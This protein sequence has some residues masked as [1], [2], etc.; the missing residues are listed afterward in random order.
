MGKGSSFSDFTYGVGLNIN[1]SSFKQVKNDLKINLDNLSKMVK[2]Y[3]EILKINPDA[4]LS[5]LFNEMVKIKSIVDGINSS[6]NSFSGFV[7][8]GVLTRISSLE[9]SLES[10]RSMSNEVKTNLSDL[11]ASLQSALSP[12]KEAGKTKIPGTFDNLFGKTTDHSTQIQTYVEQIKTLENEIRT[13]KGLFDEI[14]TSFNGT[15]KLGQGADTNQIRAW[16]ENF[17]DL[18]DI[19]SDK[20]SLNSDELSRYSQQVVD[21]GLKLNNA[22]NSMSPDQLKKTFNVDGGYISE[23]RGYIEDV[24]A[25]FDN[26]ISTIE[27]KQKTLNEKLTSARAEQAKYEA[28][29]SKKRS[30]SKSMGVIDDYTAQVPITPKINESDWVTKINTSIANIEGSIKPVVLTPTFSHNSKSIEKEIADG[31]A[32]INHQVKVNLN[33]VDGLGESFDKKIKDIDNQ[34]LAAKKQL[35]S[36]TSFKIKFEYEDGENFK[37]SAGKI[38]DQFKNIKAS[39]YIKNG[40]KFL[41]DVVDLRTQAIQELTN[42][43]A[44][45][46]V[47]N[48]NTELSNLST[49]REDIEKKIGNIGVNLNIQNLPQLMAQ[50]TLAKDTIESAYSNGLVGMPAGT[51][52]EVTGV[53]NATSNIEQLSEAAKAAKE[54]LEKCK[55]ALQ[56]LTT[57]GFDA[58]EFLQLGDLSKNG[59]Q[60]KGSVEKLEKLLKRR[61]ELKKRLYDDKTSWREKYPE[62]NG[63]KSVAKKMFLE[64]D[65]EL[66]KMDSELNQILQKQIAYTQ[67]RYEQSEKILQQE[68][69][70]AS[71]KDS[72]SN[73]V[74]NV[75]DSEKIKK[76][77]N[78]LLELNNL[79]KELQTNGFK[80]SE[81]LKIGDIGADGNKIEESTKKLKSLLAEYNKLKKRTTLVKDEGSDQ[82]FKRY[83]KAKGDMSKVQKMIAKDEQKMQK[84]ESELNQ[85]S[86]KQIAF[87]SSRASSLQKTLAT[88]KQITS[89]NVKQDKSSQ[90]GSDNVGVNQKL[91]MSAEEAKAKIKSLNSVLSDQKKILK[92]LDTNGINSSSLVRLGEWDKET[93]SFKKNRQEMQALVNRYKELQAARKQAGETKVVG[94]EA[95]LRGKLTSILIQQKQHASEIIAQNQSELKAAKEIAKAYRDINNSKKT[96]VDSKTSSKA[97][98]DID[99]LLIKLNKAKEALELLKTKKLDALTETGLGDKKNRLGASGSSQSFDQLIAEY[100]ALIQKRN[101]LEKSGMNISHPEYVAYAKQFQ[102]VEQQLNVIYNDQLK[103]TESRVKY[104]DTQIAKAKELLQIETKQ[105]AETKNQ[106]TISTVSKTATSGAQSGSAVVKL[107]GAT[108]GSLA[109]DGTLQSIDGKVGNILS[110]L[111]G[112]L[113][114]SSSAVSI[115]ASNVVVSGS[116]VAG[117]STTTGNNAAGKS[118]NVNNNMVNAAQGQKELNAEIKNTAALTDEVLAKSTVVYNEMSKEIARTTDVYKTMDGVMERTE[119][120][121]LFSHG[122]DAP[123]T[124]E[125]V[126]TVYKTNSEAYQNLYNDYIKSLSIQKQIEQQI[127]SSGGSTEKLKEELKVRQEITSGL[128]LQLSKYTQLYT[129]QAKQEAMLQ[130]TKKAQQEMNKMQGADRDKFVNKQN[131]DIQKIV[132]AAQSKYD[133]MQFSMQQSSVPMADAAIRKFKEYGALLDELKIKQQQIVDNP[134]LLKDEGYANNFATLLKQMG[135]VES[136]F[137]GLQKSSK[138]FLSK[139][140][141]L[142][143]IKPLDQTFDPSNIEQMRNAMQG[144]ANQVGLGSAKLIDFSNITKTAFFEVKDGSGHVQQLAVSYDAA[145]NSLGRYVVKTKESA[146]ETQVFINSLKKSF[147]N[148]ARYIASF[149]SI[150]RLW[151]IIKQGFTYV[152]DIDSALTDLK[153]VTD[154]TDLSYSKFLDNM[155]ETGKRVGATVTDLT[156]MA[157][158][159]ARLGYSMQEAG[160]L[161]ESTAILMNVS[162]FSDATQASEALISTMQ[163]FQYTADQSQH[164]VDI[165]NE[166]GNNYAISSDGIATALQHSA[167]ALMEAGNS[168]EQ[169]VAIIAAANK[170]VQDPNSVGTAMRTIALR[171]RGTS[172]QVLEEMGEETDGVI[173]SVSKLQSKIKALSGV[174]ILTATGDYKDTYTILKEIGSVWEDMSDIDQAALLELMAGKNRANTLSAILSNMEDLEDA[175]NDALKAEGSALRENETYLNSIQGRIDIFN[176]SVQTMWMHFVDTDA[177]KNF[178]NLGTSIIQV[179]DKMGVLN[180]AFAGLLSYMNMSSKFNL[181]FAKMFGIHDK[182][183]GWLYKANPQNANAIANNQFYASLQNYKSV[184]FTMGS[185]GEMAQQI[186]MLNQKWG[187]GQT[188]LVQYVNGLGDAD[189]AL[190]AYAA[191]VKDGQYSMAGYQEFIMQ[192]NAALKASSAAARGAAIA[193]QFL[194]TAM[195]IGITMLASFAINSLIK[196]FDDMNTSAEEIEEAFSSAISKTQEVEKSFRSLKESASD[197]I[198]RFA[199]LAKGVDK[200]GNNVSLTDGEYEEFISMNNRLAELFPEINMG[201]D[202]NGN[203]MLSLSYTADNLTESLNKLVEAERKIANTEIAKTIP[204]I[205]AGINQ[206]TK[207]YKEEHDILEK[208]IATFEEAKAKLDEI[209]SADNIATLK[210]TYGDSWKKYLEKTIAN[211]GIAN[212]AEAAWGDYSNDQDAEAWEAMMS[213]YRDANYQVDW[214]VVLNSK[215]FTSRI[216]GFEKQIYDTDNRISKEWASINPIITAWLGTDAEYLELDGEMQKIVSSMVNNIDFSKLGLSNEAGIKQYVREHILYP[217]ADASP[218]VQKKFSELMSID[219]KDISAKDYIKKIKNLVRELSD[220]TGIDYNELLQST[221]YDQTINRY[222]QVVN[223]IHDILSDSITRDYQAYDVFTKER[224]GAYVDYHKQLNELKDKIYDLSPD[225]LTKAFDIVKTYGITTWDDLEK[226][227]QNKTFDIVLEYD[228]EKEGLDNL[229]SAIEESISATGLSAESIENLEKRYKDLD[230]YDPAKLFER[231]AHGIHL[232]SQALNELEAEYEKQN[233]TDLD[234]KITGL[235]DTYNDLTDQI[236]ECSDAAKRSELYDQRENV[237]QQINDAATL[238]AQY[239]ALTSAYNKWQNAQSGGN[240]R[241]MY[242]SIHSGKQEIDE[243]ISRGWVDDGTKAYLELLS[244][245]DLSTS[246]VEKVLDVYKELNNE[247]AAGYN[248]YDFFTVD[249]NGE[250]TT[251]G[252]YNFF[253]TVMAKQKELGEEWVKIDENGNYV[254]DFGVNGDKAI[255]DALGISEEIVQIILKAAQDAGFEIK[256]DSP[257]SEL[258]D[259]QDDVKTI[260]DRLKKLGVTDY[261]FNINTGNLDDAEKQI[262]ELEK[263]LSNLK[264]EDG[265]LKVGVSEDDYFKAQSLLAALIYQKQQLEDPVVLSINTEDADTAAETAIQK[266]KEYKQAYN[267]FEIGV[268]MGEDVTAIQTQMDSIIN[269]VT[270]EEKEILVGLGIDLSQTDP[271]KINEQIK[272][273][274]PEM[275]IQCGIDPTLVEEYKNSEQS[276]EGTVIWGNNDNAVTEWISQTHEAIGTVIWGNDVAGVQTN[277]EAN[278]HIRWSGLF[279]GGKVNGTAN[280]DGNWGAKKTETSLVGE[281]GPEILV[282]NGRWTTVGANGAE[283]TQVKKGDIIFNHKQTEELL[284]NGHVTGRGKSYASGTAYSS[285]KGPGRFTV[286]SA[287]DGGNG[288]G[289]IAKAASDAAD[290]LREVFDWIAVRLEE[291]TEELDLKSAKLENAVGFKDKHSIIN[292]MIEINKVLSEN[293]VKGVK[294]YERYSAELLKKVPAAYREMAQDGSILISE[295]VGEANKETLEAIENYREWAQKVADLNQQ[296]EETKTEI[297]D[298][299][300]QKFDVVADEY[301]NILSILEAQNDKFDAQV[302]LMEDRGYVASEAYYAAMI[303]NIKEQNAELE[304]EQKA[305]QSVL[306][307]Q[308]KLGN[309]QVGSEQ[310]YE[311]VEAIYDVSSS[312]QDCASSLEEYQNAINEIYWDNFENLTDRLDYLKDETQNLIDLFD[313]EDLVVTPETEDG[314][315]ADQVEWSKEGLASLGLYAQQMEIAE[316]KARQYAEAIDDL[317]KEYQAGHYSEDEYYEKLNELKDAQYES[318]EAY[319]DAQDAI[320][321]LNQTR[322]DSIKKGIDKEIEAYEELINAKKELLDA[323]KDAHDFQKT[324]MDQQ[325]NISDIERK[326]AALAYDDSASARAKRAQLEAELAE[327]RAE[328]DE[329]YYDRSIEEQQ[330]A[331]D[332]ELENFQKEKDEEVKKMEEY[333]EDIK[334][335]VT[336][337]LATIQ[338][339]ES[340]IY[341]TLIEKA[342]EYNLT[343]SESLLTPWKDGSLAVSNYQETFDTAISSTMDQLEALKD[344]WQEVIDKMVYAS[345]IDIDNINKENESYVS[346]T[347]TPENTAKQNT[348]SADSKYNIYTVQS[349][350]NLWAIAERQLGSGSRWQEIYDLNKN[351]IS[352]PDLIQPGWNLKIPKYAKGT[353]GVPNDQW[354]ILDELGEELRLIPDGNGRLAY[355]KKGTGVVP[356]DLTANLMEWG[357]LDPSDMLERNRPEIGAN[358]SVINNN[359]EIHIDASVGELLHVEHL[360]GSNPADVTKLIDKAWDKRMKELNGYIRRYTNR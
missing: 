269:S 234:Q 116:N 294:E 193:H 1:A 62:A 256:I 148:V 246:S 335:V 32:S 29:I 43:P 123:K 340:G 290:E 164:V 89:E 129:E 139:I 182:D 68:K 311:M 251:E 104:Y 244:G 338:A 235:V 88:E 121:A 295:F 17:E 308:V 262:Q 76:V 111:S 27:T 98:K 268:A 254:F 167:S 347:K 71:V 134:D 278:G 315:S 96:S 302:S 324:V 261:V 322:I 334:Q 120:S 107:D 306:D 109:K 217:I 227:L 125:H 47:S 284:K 19:L 229:S 55:T 12:L 199:E 172:V 52:K 250:S 230:S 277:F 42:I 105:T 114:V 267:A 318:I 14:E 117:G 195:S 354:A 75:E 280:A 82:W 287:S 296:L 201:M 112:G 57:K 34:V 94:E 143:D 159:W 337:S 174:D 188:A 198:P 37:N 359:T 353:T 149:G 124:F 272:A 219:A 127:Q 218:E 292:D 299:A 58:P 158:E 274:T 69:Q 200:F 28:T 86:Q 281:L 300:K 115:N 6:N 184:A 92:D 170:V 316:Y 102:G 181:D 8:K 207:G 51:I 180:T 119:I 136:K 336:D 179:I 65:A 190:K 84:I 165:L 150:Y 331:L 341:D 142:N 128:D 213:K 141:S 333:L 70:I 253:D 289:S 321:E 40:K 242:D 97:T 145:T 349:G 312:I 297:A 263:A 238:T 351:V 87:L 264:N 203:A 356:A 245:Q 168:L 249:K 279:G 236:N 196:F 252:I 247:I 255:A 95:S 155:A 314:W 122:K 320:K 106:G 36:S 26:L 91:S 130:A 270:S 282:R 83:P 72:T 49:F 233:K 202:S 232:N 197:I 99:A 310:W 54:N 265:T 110:S 133:A 355:M 205:L 176:N 303:K 18:R 305:L 41:Q 319:Y 332:K 212:M 16:L 258:N 147:Q 257:T 183:L 153:K 64:F 80:S 291:I 226:H 163:A 38:I 126:A 214:T 339:N 154:E 191:S 275:L 298:L 103:Y 90:S 22:F 73:K 325:K 288:S 221:G 239:N 243:E 313:S 101:E 4:D 271:E 135:D 131:K 194:N 45:I 162:E 204:D 23:M 157:S 350:D 152:K 286:T 61:D 216:E 35:E 178:V 146:S 187:E 177:A 53:T 173:E 77:K 345:N 151:A 21:I 237:L 9:T 132:N 144:F 50:A 175:Y 259:F 301:D 171:L 30:S 25:T 211:S 15:S 342:D 210:E 3:G 169:S 78:E 352:N 293:L 160:K 59:K 206:N 317:S 220:E 330:N 304:K 31:T 79:I 231:T 307:E 189:V 60:I 44:T 260:N 240:D 215:E 85:Y 358:P 273:I 13:L 46:V 360:D 241:D 266:I 11:Q 56:N 2:S 140:Q 344:K 24:G 323:D 224:L 327:A 329:T 343:L 93:G 223:G 81:F 166:I 100:N 138:N 348:S 10:V 66:K 208:R 328:L 113:N 326:L 346:A 309:I 20:K 5:S 192:H 39:F 7:D 357:K 74:V 285:G 222:R 185:D 156:K 228:T 209:Y 276:I 186:D 67:S 108:L 118:T 137:N 63:D 225:E 283:F 33:V 248:I 161:A 48:A